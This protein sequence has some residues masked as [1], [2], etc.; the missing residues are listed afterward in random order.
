[1]RTAT[2]IIIL[3][4]L[5]LSQSSLYSQTTLFW[6]DQPTELLRSKELTAGNSN[7]NNIALGQYI[8]R[9]VRVDRVN[10]KVYWTVGG[11]E[12][13]KRANLDGSN[14]EIIV[15]NTSNIAIIE[16]DNS[17]NRL[18][19]TESG[20]GEIQSCNLDG[21]DIQV[22]VQGTGIVLGLDVDPLNH[23]FYWTE[24]S[25]GLIR[26]ADLDGANIVNI[27][28]TGENVY[29]LQIDVPN[30]HIYFTNRS[31]NKIE[32]VNFNGSNR[33]DIISTLGQAGAIAL[34]LYEGEMYWLERDMGTISKADLD[35]SNLTEL[36]NIPNSSFSGLDVMVYPV[37]NEQLIERAEA[38]FFFPNPTKNTISIPYEFTTEGQLS[39]YNMN[40]QLILQKTIHQQ[41]N[42][43]DV[44]F[45]LSGTYVIELK[46]KDESWKIGKLIKQ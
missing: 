25:N 21:S 46:V 30:Q 38:L 23:H 43:F 40:S 2:S 44:S 5:I 4:F 33:T 27:L 26:R 34:D 28:S 14:P 15:Q 11:D 9:R 6:G 36:I 12:T 32:R 41:M 24:S 3:F 18:Y 16:I 37:A 1:M 17:T 45:L 10:E 22:L 13:I 20:S 42:T 31:T 39:I 29:D 19:F 8:I 35:G 7:T